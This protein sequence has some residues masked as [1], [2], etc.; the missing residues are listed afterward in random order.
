MLQERAP[1][2]SCNHLLRRVAPVEACGSIWALP[3]KAKSVLS[4]NNDM[5]ACSINHWH[6]NRL[7]GAKGKA[8]SSIARLKPK[9]QIRTSCTRFHHLLTYM[10]SH[11]K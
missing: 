9:N 7:E 1:G 11:L 10:L 4:V 3:V 5:H 2:L 6:V 8:V